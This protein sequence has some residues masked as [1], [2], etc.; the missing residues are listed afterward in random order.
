MKIID[1]LRE[2][3]VELEKV[4]WPS[5]QQ[6]IRLTFIVIFITVMVAFFVG[7]VDFG[8]VNLSQYLIQ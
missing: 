7:V 3:K 8:L 2:V 6:T 5:R 4:V 1:F